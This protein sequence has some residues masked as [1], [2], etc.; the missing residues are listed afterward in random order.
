MQHLTI[1]DVDVDNRDGACVI[2]SACIYRWRAL[3]CYDHRSWSPAEPLVPPGVPVIPTGTAEFGGGASWCRGYR[4]AA[5]PAR[6]M[7]RFPRTWI[8]SGVPT[9]SR[10]E[11]FTQRDRLC[12]HLSGTQSFDMTISAS[13][14]C[15]SLT[16]ARIAHRALPEFLPDEW[17]QGLA[18]EA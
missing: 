4:S 2:V 5:T 17:G 8:C 6:R 15:R 18:T 1:V 10:V 9:R 12:R 13:G 7:S 11:A 14:S 16:A 3:N